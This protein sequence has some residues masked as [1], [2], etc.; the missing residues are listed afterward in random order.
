MH[1]RNDLALGNLIRTIAQQKKYGVQA[2]YMSAQK[3]AVR[4]E[5][6]PGI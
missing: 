4:I 1:I 3:R 6:Q 2:D 5:W